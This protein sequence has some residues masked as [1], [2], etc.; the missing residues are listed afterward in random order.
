MNPPSNSV[1]E[2]PIDAPAAMSATRPMYWS[3]RRELWESRSIYVAPLVVAAVTLFG[4]L[5]STIRLPAKMRALSALDPAKQRAVVIV[6]YDTA[7]SVIIL[8]GFIVGV[9]YCL[10]ALNSERRDRSILFWKSLPVSDRTTVL[11]KASIP[12]VVQPLIAFMVAHAT[13]LIML[14]LS[15]AVLAGSGLN[16]ATLWARLPLFQMPLIMFYGLT[17]HTLWFAPIYGWLLLVSA[18]SRRATFLWAALPFFAIYVVERIAFGKSY[19]AA[20]L[21]YRVVGAM[22]EAF[23]VNAGHASITRLSQLEPLKFLSGSGLWFGLAFAA[24]FLAAAVRLRR[25]REPI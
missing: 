20:M 2:F 13:Q 25:N 6:P 15:T 17:V 14:L 16:P 7:A 11:S 22:T 1:P 12:L 4:F 24:A 8:T 10:D 9:F 3:V 21:K 5:I 19:I 18:W 23:A